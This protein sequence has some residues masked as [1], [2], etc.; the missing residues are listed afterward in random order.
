MKTLKYLLLL[1]VA[2]ARPVMAQAE[3]KVVKIVD[4]GKENT[5]S[6]TFTMK[7]GMTATVQVLASGNLLAFVDTSKW[8]IRME[9]DV[10]TGEVSRA[11]FSKKGKGF[12]PSGFPYKDDLLIDDPIVI[13][14]PIEKPIVYR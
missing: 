11:C 4:K 5:N 7:K 12:C 8:V 1:A 2:M 6:T 10:A 9:K 3:G 13:E 14:K